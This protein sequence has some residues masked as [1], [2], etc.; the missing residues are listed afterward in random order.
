MD[1][2]HEAQV[3][4]FRAMPVEQLVESRELRGFD[5]SFLGEVVYLIYASYGKR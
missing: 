2:R 3:E 5:P 4:L 1:V